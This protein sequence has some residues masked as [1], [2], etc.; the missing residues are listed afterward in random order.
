MCIESLVRTKV[1]AA[2]GLVGLSLLLNPSP[3]RSQDPWTVQVRQQLI[4]SAVAAGYNGLE[5]THEPHTGVLDDEEA[6]VVNLRLHAGTTY[7]VA[8]ACDE[9]CGDLDLQ[10]FDENWNAVS[11]DTEADDRPVVS[12]TPIRTTVFHIRTIMADCKAS[13]CAFGLGVFGGR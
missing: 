10:L 6:F 2:A 1:L 5:L 4:G 8:G 7:V 3:V 9:D 12:V 11:T 13:P